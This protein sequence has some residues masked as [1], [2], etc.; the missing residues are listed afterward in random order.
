[1]LQG[2]LG[3]RFTSDSCKQGEKIYFLLRLVHVCVQF[4]SLCSL[5]EREGCGS[6]NQEQG[7]I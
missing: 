6:E 2:L 5:L 4:S 1:M 3:H 7:K